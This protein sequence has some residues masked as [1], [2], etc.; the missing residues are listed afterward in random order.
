MLSEVE[1]DVDEGEYDEEFNAA[2]EWSG[3]EKACAAVQ[4]ICMKTLKAQRGK[5]TRV[6]AWDAAKSFRDTE[7]SVMRSIGNLK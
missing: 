7:D 4:A 3:C 5:H 2:G 1:K 6:N